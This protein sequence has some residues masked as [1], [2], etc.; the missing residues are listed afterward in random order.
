[1][2]G[3]GQGLTSLLLT[4]AEALTNKAKAKAKAAVNCP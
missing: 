3:H 4:K 1:M 2:A